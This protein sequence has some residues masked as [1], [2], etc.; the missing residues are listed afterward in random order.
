MGVWAHETYISSVRNTHGQGPFSGCPD[1]G[2]AFSDPRL[3]ELIP[4]SSV[5]FR[6]DSLVI[7]IDNHTES[8]ILFYTSESFGRVRLSN[9]FVDMGTKQ[10]SSNPVSP[11]DKP[12]NMHV[13]HIHDKFGLLGADRWFT[14]LRK[15]IVEKVSKKFLLPNSVVVVAGSSRSF[16]EV[17]KDR[18]TYKQALRAFV[19]RLF[20][21]S[22]FTRAP[23]VWAGMPNPPVSSRAEF[24]VHPGTFSCDI[25]EEILARHDARGFVCVRDFITL[26]AHGKCG[27]PSDRNYTGI[28]PPFE[29]MASFRDKHFLSNL[30]TSLNA[31]AIQRDTGVI[32]E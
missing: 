13:L 6:A 28:P 11:W 9:N 15:F 7:P 21:L 31:L 17:T 18:N 16:L 23:V 2:I 14:D 5:K 3:D 8:N 32:R 30:A 25:E 29:E 24:F 12:Q 19:T 20:D 22:A 10:E 27:R 1:F 26:N 4:H